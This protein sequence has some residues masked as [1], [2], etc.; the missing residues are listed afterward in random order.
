M[1]VTVSGDK[2]VEGLA[3]IIS[4]TARPVRPLSA[5]SQD[6]VLL[7]VVANGT[8]SRE[9]LQDLRDRVDILASDFNCSFTDLQRFGETN[10]WSLHMPVFH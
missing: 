2:L 8:S 5:P 4:I 9:V 1:S 10:T 3:E 7:T 6:Q